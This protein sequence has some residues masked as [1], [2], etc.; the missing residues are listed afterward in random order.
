[1]FSSIEQNSS[2]LFKFLGII[3]FPDLVKQHI[4][5]FMHK[6]HNQLLSSVFNSS[7]TKVDQTHSYTRYK[8]RF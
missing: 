5:V 2:P 8:T 3:I 4:A 7:F 6:Y 1:M